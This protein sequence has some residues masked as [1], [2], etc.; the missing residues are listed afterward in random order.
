MIQVLLG[1]SPL[2]DHLRTFFAAF[3]EDGQG[4]TFLGQ[5]FRR[6]LADGGVVGE[7]GEDFAEHRTVFEGHSGA[8][9]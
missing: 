2:D 6:S 1:V 8:R 3:L 5:V 9:C 7:T 4:M